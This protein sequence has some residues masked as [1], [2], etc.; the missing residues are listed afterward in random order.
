MPL[1][2]PKIFI[3]IGAILLFWRS[4]RQVCGYL[5]S[6]KNENENAILSFWSLEMA[7]KVLVI[8]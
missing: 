7:M 3:G 5:Q 6:S 4:A 1:Q 2:V 8:L